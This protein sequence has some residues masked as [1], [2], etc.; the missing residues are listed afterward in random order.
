MR[1]VWAAFKN[2]A[3]LFA[4]LIVLL[5]ANIGV[6]VS[7]RTFYEIRLDALLSN[8]RELEKQRDEARRVVQQVQDAVGRMTRTRDEL[9]KF[10]SETLG[11][12]RERL[13]PLI[14]DIY[15]MTRKAG[16]RP[17]SISYE[18]DTDEDEDSIGLQFQVEGRY[19][20]IKALLAEFELNPRLL[21]LEQVGLAGGDTDPDVLKVSLR[22]A[23]YFRSESVK[24]P[25]KVRQAPGRGSG[26][27]R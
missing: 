21:V 25:R 26:G 23:H 18:S 24:T 7:Y 3:G 12:R 2:R 5:A 20:E 9:E 4:V 22:V 1:S 15:T 14:Q 8:Q 6:L 10:F 17:E 11:V 13:A 27:K 16:M 19:P